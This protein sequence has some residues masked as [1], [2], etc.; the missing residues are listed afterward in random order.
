MNVRY[1]YDEW[2]VSKFDEYR[3]LLLARYMCVLKNRWMCT[4]HAMNTCCQKLM[5]VFSPRG[6]CIQTRMIVSFEYGANHK[7]KQ[8]WHRPFWPPFATHTLVALSLCGTAPHGKAPT[9][10]HIS[11]GIREGFSNDHK[12]QCADAHSSLYTSIKLW[13]NTFMTRWRHIYEILTAHIHTRVVHIHL[14]L[15]LHIHHAACTHLSI[16]ASTH[17]SDKD[18]R[19]RESKILWFVRKTYE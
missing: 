18:I 10:N 12:F 4:N 14:I 5:N 2:V 11:L 9:I 3:R 1:R 15:T 17:L 16:F 7:F 13:H 19:T 8:E 6:E